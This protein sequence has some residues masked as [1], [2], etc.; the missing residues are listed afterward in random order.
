MISLFSCLNTCL[1]GSESLIVAPARVQ[2]Y[3]CLSPWNK[4]VNNWIRIL[5]LQYSFSLLPVFNF[6]S[7]LKSFLLSFTGFS[8]HINN[9]HL[10]NHLWFSGTC[11]YFCNWFQVLG[12]VSRKALPHEP[13]VSAWQFFENFICQAWLCSWR[14]AISEVLLP[15]RGMKLGVGKSYSRCLLWFQNYLIMFLIP[16]PQ[17]SVKED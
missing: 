5:F 16:S 3:I 2:D 4:K 10:L 13:E 11:C 8:L 9:V 14:E 12:W 6:T 15:W 1:W 7:N 17:V